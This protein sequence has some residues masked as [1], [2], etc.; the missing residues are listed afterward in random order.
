MNMLTQLALTVAVEL[1][2]NKESHS[3]SQQGPRYGRTSSRSNTQTDT[4]TLEERRTYVALV[5][6]T[7]TYGTRN[8]KIL[9]TLLKHD[10]VN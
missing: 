2:L 7:S 1:D 10:I 9:N 5:K 8:Q 4:R 3:A 6:L